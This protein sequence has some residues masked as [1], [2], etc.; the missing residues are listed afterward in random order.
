MDDGWLSSCQR[1]WGGCGGSDALPPALLPFPVLSRAAATSVP[2]SQ[3]QGAGIR[4]SATGTWCRLGSSR[5]GQ[6]G[7]RGEIFMARSN[8]P[9]CMERRGCFTLGLLT[10]CCLNACFAKLKQIANSRNRFCCCL[11]FCFLVFFRRKREKGISWQKDKGRQLKCSLKL[12]GSISLSK[13]PHFLRRLPDALKCL[14]RQSLSS[15]LILAKFMD[16]DIFAGNRKEGAS[17][18]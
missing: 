8:R 18:F 14:V 11:V 2:G 10:S 1:R 4:V 17:P 3:C 13:W 5:N 15:Y 9:G 7:H 16:P 6:T 12:R